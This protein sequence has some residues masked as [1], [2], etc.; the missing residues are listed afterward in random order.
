MSGS[1]SRVISMEKAPLYVRG[2]V[3]SSDLGE[4]K[5][6]AGMDQGILP[7]LG[8]VFSNQ[9]PGNVFLAKDA[10]DVWSPF[11]M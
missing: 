3:K 6:E 1:K 5:D 2:R 8:F 9:I 10:M 11:H 4:I 7:L